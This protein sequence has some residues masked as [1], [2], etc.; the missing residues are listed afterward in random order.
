MTLEL[1]DGYYYEDHIKK[2]MSREQR[3]NMPASRATFNKY[4]INI[5]ISSFDDKDLDKEDITAHHGMLSI[6]QL[7]STSNLA[8]EEFNK[9]VLSISN[10]TFKML[11]I[12]RLH[13]YPDSIKNDSINPNILE[14]FNLHNKII[15]AE[16]AKNNI[17]RILK[18]N[19]NIN[20]SFKKRG[21]LILCLLITSRNNM[22]A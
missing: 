17:T 6:K 11:N 4:T 22:V 5:D 15:V 16:S 2:I 12:N 1:K 8:K 9:D 19:L 18:R 10:R 14:N 7:D 21:S 20:K 3:E 13:Q